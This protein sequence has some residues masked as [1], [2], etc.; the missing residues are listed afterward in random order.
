MTA[1]WMAHAACRGMDLRLWY[2]GPGHSH[3]VAGIRVCRRC[4]VRTECLKYDMAQVPTD[5]W[6]TWG[7]LPETTRRP[8]K[9]ARARARA[10]AS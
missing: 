4:P 6:G 7:G 9:R 2:P 1:E 8:S 10:E 5:R 3:T